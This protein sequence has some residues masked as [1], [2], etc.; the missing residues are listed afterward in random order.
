MENKVKK[1]SLRTG[2][3]TS[4]KLFHITQ[5]KIQIEENKHAIHKISKYQILRL[6]LYCFA[7]AV[8]VL[9]NACYFSCKGATS[10]MGGK[11]RAPAGSGDPRRGVINPLPPAP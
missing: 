6:T 5:N 1:T 8:T 7:A 4:K 2:I 3:D 10:P 9:S 11:P